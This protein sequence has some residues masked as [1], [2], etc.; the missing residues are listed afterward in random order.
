MKKDYF[1]DDVTGRKSKPKKV[2]KKNKMTFGKFILIIISLAV[3][4]LASFII[5]VKVLVP[6]YDLKELIPQKAV[7][8]IEEDI[9]GNTT[10]TEP[11]TVTTTRPETTTEKMMDYFEH[12]ELKSN[13]E[14]A[15]NQLG[16]L[17]NGGLVG[18][19]TSYIYHISQ[20][21][22][23]YRITP[24]Y[25]G[26][27][28]IYKTKH[29]LSSLNL[30]GEYIYFVDETKGR[31]RRL[32]KGA[33]KPETIAENVRFAYVYD[34]KV[35]FI[36]NNNALCVMDLK[37]LEPRTIYYSEDNELKLVGI[38]KHRV[39][40]TVNKDGVLDFLTI[41]NRAREDDASKFRESVSDDECDKFVM[42]NG[43]LYYIKKN[44][45]KNGRYF[46]VR[47][48]FGSEKIFELKETRTNRCYPITDKNRLFYASIENNQLVM[49][50]FNM[51]SKR[52]KIMLR[53]NE[54]SDS[55]DDDKAQIF[56]GGEYDFIIGDGNYKASSNQ[57]SAT[58]VMN[59]SKGYWSYS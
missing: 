28:R 3:A 25:E 30:R 55:D 4:A 27:T 9:K 6:D 44:P 32:G 51:N 31:L 54:L 7:D 45:D 16:N 26:Y 33:S 57:T 22:G 49:K 47:Q 42:E 8:F 59:F 15:G 36:T 23:I 24:S 50:E 38:S 11:T 52:T 53:S 19:D 43:F 37:K 20:G 41:D 17:L 29:T 12:K 58:N 2:K 35:Y 5:T 40:F 34:S 39:F 56:H 13:D 48:K 21:R 1:E 46:V 18:T 14:K 10:T